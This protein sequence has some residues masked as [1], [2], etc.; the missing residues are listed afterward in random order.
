MK[1]LLKRTNVRLA[2]VGL[3]LLIGGFAIYKS[4]FWQDDKQ[5]KQVAKTKPKKKKKTVKPIPDT[6]DTIP[7]VPP[8]ILGQ[9]RTVTPL[10]NDPYGSPSP[11][12][13]VGFVADK[14]DDPPQG[15]PQDPNRSHIGDEAFQPPS[16]LASTQ[17]SDDTTSFPPGS[18]SG[19]I[20]PGGDTTSFQPGGDTQFQP[21][22]GD[23]TSFQPG[24]DTTSFQ[25]GGDTTSFQPG[26]ANETQPRPTGTGDANPQQSQPIRIGL[27]DDESPAGANLGVGDDTGSPARLTDVAGAAD[28]GQ[29]NGVLTPQPPDGLGPAAP[30]TRSLG[31]PLPGGAN[32]GANGASITGAAITGAATGA[33]ITGAATERATN[34]KL[35][36]LAAAAAAASSSGS[37]EFSGGTGTS[38]TSMVEQNPITRRT[39]G[40]DRGSDTPQGRGFDGGSTTPRLGEGGLGTP[41]PSGNGGVTPRR[42][43]T[44]IDMSATRANPNAGDVPGPAALDGPQAPSL[45]VEKQ[46]PAEI[47]VNRPAAFT[48]IVKNVGRI[49]AEDVTVIDRVPRGT[50]LISTTPTATAAEGTLLWQIARLEPGQEARFTVEVNPQVE[51]EIG[52][53]AQVAFLTKATAR[54][55][56]TKPELQLALNS[57]ESV[58]IG[59]S[60]NLNLT[61]TN[62]GSGAATGVVLEADIPPG[63]SHP[64]GQKLEYGVG[65]I[66]PGET[67]RFSLP[68]KAESAGFVENRLRIRGD[69]DV[70]DLKSAPLEIVAPQLRVGVVGPSKRYLERQATYTVQV[71]NPGTASARD[72]Q[73]VAHLP[74]G[75]QFLDTDNQGRYDPRTHA[76]YWQLQEL[77]PAQAGQVQLTTMPV[78]T[79][80]QLVRVEGSAQLGLSDTYEH[81]VKVDSLSELVFTIADVADPIELTS[82]T[83]YEIRI[84]NQGSKKDTNIQ[85]A[86][87]FP[88]GL[89]PLEGEGPT[90]VAV[91]GQVVRFAPVAQMNPRDELVYRVRA[92]GLVAG[93]HIVRS[94]VSSTEAGVSV[95][96][97]EHT[98]VYTDND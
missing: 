15:I 13:T 72:V 70:S 12:E 34:S 49:A 91:Q 44:P 80:D 54:T 93:D 40:G 69:G 46:A 77:P 36:E 11:A 94:Q 25:P 71:A 86:L 75:M 45:S 20:Q 26:T 63:L 10:P 60:I 4:G 56:C 38:G 48:V 83:S 53:V 42:L 22:G 16:D 68:L 88:P 89:Q 96:K 59:E 47:Q 97:E 51:G 3:V 81:A 7:P 79:G 61:V 37:R 76:V 17:L 90:E 27:A 21:M 73:V 1:K 28:S 84:R 57:P 23:T 95:T 98:K 78:E 29:G 35:S 82:E 43:G 5:P 14:V 65:T 50:M 32:D 18:E 2:L 64:A 67:K 66:R 33:A 9:D 62:L 74:K 58:L 92:K 6:D 8:G 55:I 24:G 41:I 87:E 39:L 31:A 19:S 85:L 30:T 52:S